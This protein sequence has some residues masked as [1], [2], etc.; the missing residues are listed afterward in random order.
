[1]V[2]ALDAFRAEAE[3]GLA[4]HKPSETAPIV[5]APATQVR[6]SMVPL[7]VEAKADGYHMGITVKSSAA[8]AAKM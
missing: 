3:G 8:G 6:R 4:A 1:M 2:G 7:C 5:T